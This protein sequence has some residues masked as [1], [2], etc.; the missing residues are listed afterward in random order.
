MA[1]QLVKQGFSIVST[2]PGGRS[3]SMPA[4]Y[5]PELIA[6]AATP[7]APDGSCLG[8]LHLRHLEDLL[9]RGCDGVALF[10]TTGEGPAFTVAE[11]RKGLD[12]ALD[13][14]IA[15]E[16]LVVAAMSA[17]PADALE[18]CRHAAKAGVTRLLVMP[19]FFFRGAAS[20]DGLLRFYGDLV[21]A[22]GDD[23]LRILLYHFPDMSGAVI[24]AELVLELRRRFGAVIDGVKD[25]AGDLEAS[26]A[27]I[28]ALPDMRVLVGTEVHLPAAVAAGGGGTICGLANVAPELVRELML[29]TNPTRIADQTARLD[30]L[31]ALLSTAPF[32]ASL[33]AMLALTTGEPAW[34]L[35]QAPMAALDAEGMRHLRDG[36]HEQRWLGQPSER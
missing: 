31:D 16:R 22:L 9:E 23:N 28:R 29:E 3:P 5:A 25:S 35:P 2:R 24:T 13:A 10:G 18:L 27:L 19:P 36:L 20:P 14:G 8:A 33:K 17:A 1:I 32:A 4:G 7:A 6:A 26:L 34:A 11:R 15:P 21:E 30:A 12:R